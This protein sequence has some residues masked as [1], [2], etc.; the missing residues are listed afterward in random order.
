MWNL[1]TADG[2]LEEWDL[3]WHRLVLGDEFERF[4][5]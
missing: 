5:H 3:G 4:S 2:L 1:L